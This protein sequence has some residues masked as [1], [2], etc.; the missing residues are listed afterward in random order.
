MEDADHTRDSLRLGR[1]ESEH[2]AAED[3]RT[4]THGGEHVREVHI[5]TELSLAV[6][7]FPPVDPDLRFADDFEVFGVLQLRLVR[8]GH[9]R[10]FG[11]KLAVRR[12]APA[13]RMDDLLDPVRNDAAST[14]QRLAAAATSIVRTAA[15]A[16]RCGS[17]S[18][19]VDIL[20]PVICVRN[21]GW[22]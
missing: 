9:R 20:P 13:F 2:L 17:Y 21:T 1:I 8:N 18:E 5:H 3:R 22:L 16:R 7:L 10:R 14:P 6:H 19:L 15:P 12:A 4:Q 11:R